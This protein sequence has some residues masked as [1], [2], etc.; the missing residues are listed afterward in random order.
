MG[1]ILNEQLSAFLD[2]ELEAAELDLVSRRLAAN[3]ELRATALSY[4][5]IGDVLRDEATCPDPVAFCRQVAA[6]TQSVSDGRPATGLLGAW[7][8]W[9]RALAGSGVAAAVAVVAVLALRN[10]EPVDDAGPALT[11]PVAGQEQTV[12]AYTVPAAISRRAGAPDRLSRYYLNHSEYAVLLNGQGSLVR[13]VSGPPPQDDLE[14]ED[15]PDRPAPV[16][17]TTEP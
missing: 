17:V 15:A 8:G 11:V 10:G 4:S 6:R 9:G 7:H 1:R 13:I 2:D 12:P 3:P 14:S 16:D 5:L